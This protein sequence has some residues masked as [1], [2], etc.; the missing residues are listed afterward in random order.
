MIVCQSLSPGTDDT[1]YSYRDNYLFAV[2][3]PAYYDNDH[4][5][6]MQ[7]FNQSFCCADE[8]NNR[9]YITY[10]CVAT[11]NDLSC[12]LYGV[13]ASILYGTAANSRL[14]PNNTAPVL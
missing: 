7:F 13:E 14:Y 2:L 3:N 12:V 1:A 4:Q 5:V 9:L 6:A 11:S 8:H 10:S